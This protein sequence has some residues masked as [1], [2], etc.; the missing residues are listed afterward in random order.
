MQGISTLYDTAVGH[1]H[2]C[3]CWTLSIW[4]ASEAL[5]LLL[6][7]RGLHCMQTNTITQ[8]YKTEEHVRIIAWIHVHVGAHGFAEAAR[9]TL[10]AKKWWDMR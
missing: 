2:K 1:A 6:R 3:Q 4:H 5:Y 8:L 10:R 9:L 7:R